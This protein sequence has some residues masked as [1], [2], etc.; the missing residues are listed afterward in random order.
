MLDASTRNAQRRVK[1]ASDPKLLQQTFNQ[2][3]TSLPIRLVN[4]QL[5]VITELHRKETELSEL[6]VTSDF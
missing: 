3:K 5:I 2:G 4:L 6:L 1:T